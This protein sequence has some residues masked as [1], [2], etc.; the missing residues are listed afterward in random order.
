MI[1]TRTE[2][3]HAHPKAHTSK[4]E[5]SIRLPLKKKKN[6]NNN[7]IATTRIDFK[8]LQ[9]I[10]NQAS[11]FLL[12]LFVCLVSLRPH[13]QLGNMADGSQDCHLTILRATTHETKW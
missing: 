5:L 11:A 12:V 8:P 7:N 10:L 13:Q 1:N 2:T 6:N 3:E 4:K 9:T